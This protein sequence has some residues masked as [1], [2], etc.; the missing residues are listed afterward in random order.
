MR[1]KIKFMAAVFV[2]G[3]SFSGTGKVLPVTEFAKFSMGCKKDSDCVVD[4]TD[5]CT[6]HG[7]GMPNIA[8]FYGGGNDGGNGLLNWGKF[9]VDRNQKCKADHGITGSEDSKCPKE[10]SG[11][12]NL[13]TLCSLYTGFGGER[14]AKCRNSKCVFRKRYIDYVKFKFQEK[15]DRE[16][17]KNYSR[18]WNPTQCRNMVEWALKIPKAVVEKLRKENTAHAIK[19]M[20]PQPSVPFKKEY[21]QNPDILAFLSEGK[22]SGRGEWEYKSVDGKRLGFPK[23]TCKKNSDCVFKSTSCCPTGSGHSLPILKKYENRYDTLR[24]RACKKYS[25]KDLQKCAPISIQKPFC[26]RATV[27]RVSPSG[28]NKIYDGSWERSYCDYSSPMDLKGLSAS[29]LKY[30]GCSTPGSKTEC[31]LVSTSCCDKCDIEALNLKKVHA[32]KKSKVQEWNKKRKEICKRFTQSDIDS[33]CDTVPDRLFT[34]GEY[35]HKAFCQSLKPVCRRTSVYGGARHLNRCGIDTPMPWPMEWLANLTG[36]EDFLGG[37]DPGERDK[38]VDYE[39]VK[40]LQGY[41]KYSKEWKALLGNKDYAVLLQNALDYAKWRKPILEKEIKEFMSGLTPK[42]RDF[43]SNSANLSYLKIRTKKAREWAINTK[44]KLGLTPEQIKQVHRYLDYQGPELGRLGAD[45]PIIQKKLEAIKKDKDDDEDDDKDDDKDKPPFI[46]TLI[47][48]NFENLA[49]FTDGCKEK[50]D[51]QIVSGNCCPSG[52]SGVP[53]A[54]LDT[55]KQEYW[56]TRFK[57]CHKRFGH[58]KKL[59]CP[60]TGKYDVKPACVNSKCVTQPATKGSTGSR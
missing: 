27:T 28:T 40:A 49:Q 35:S 31:A 48:K 9:H 19:E 32:I 42:Q 11:R 33:V 5:C 16:L 50:S 53:F 24:E 12:E 58:P 34:K 6:C 38:E 59:K 7:N 51:C 54:I 21:L 60:K 29:S 43:F 45:I 46:T 39:T 30:N 13:R 23:L 25:K 2:A 18:C 15:R 26:Y 37:G 22:L 55:K 14:P 41:E 47:Y 8:I 4:T 56:K 20:G 44:H 10:P 57:E 3:F 36:N 1:F 52:H 17:G